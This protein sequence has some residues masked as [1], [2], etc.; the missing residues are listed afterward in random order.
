MQRRK[1]KESRHEKKL[2]TISFT[3]D[4]S[5]EKIFDAINKVRRWWS[6]EIDGRTNEL[7][8]EFTYRYKDVHRSTHKITEGKESPVLSPSRPLAG[9]VVPRSG[10]GWGDYTCSELI[11]PSRQH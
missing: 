8:A 1:R 6:G 2:Y 7:G 9:R 4:Q 10:A 5:F 3:V 11:F